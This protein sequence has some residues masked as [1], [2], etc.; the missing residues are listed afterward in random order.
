MALLLLLGL[1]LWRSAEDE[2]PASRTRP[3]PRG[4]KTSSRA[5]PQPVSGERA[6]DDSPRSMG[7]P[8][9]AGALVVEVLSKDAPL[10]GASVQLYARQPAE[11]LSFPAQWIGVDSGVTGADG[12]WTPPVAPGSYYVTVHAEGLAPGYVTVV[13][14]PGPARTRVRLNL[15]RAAELSGLILEKE[16]G[17]PI[18]NAEI[19]VTPPG[20]MSAPQ[21]RPDSPEDEGLL[22]TSNEAGEFMLSGL[23]PGTYRVEAQASGYARVEIPVFGIPQ[24]RLTLELSRSGQLEGTVVHADGAPAPGAEVSTTSSQYD[25]TVLTDGEGH[26][27]IDVPPGTYTVSSRQGEETGVLDAVAV[28]EGDRVRGLRVTLGAGARLSGTMLRKD[29]SPVIGAKVETWRRMAGSS[30]LAHRSRALAVTDEHG[31]FTL[32]PLAPGTHVPGVALPQRGRYR[33]PPVTLAAGEHASVVWTCEPRDDVTCQVPEATEGSAQPALAAIRG[34]VLHPLGI[35][36]GRIEVII[37]SGDRKEGWNYYSDFTGDRFDLRG[38]APGLKH[39]AVKAEDMAATVAVE[40][41][42]GELK[43]LE[44]TVTPGVTMKGRLIDEASRQPLENGWVH[45]PL[46]YMRNTMGRGGTGK[47]GRFSFAGVQPGEFLL[48]VTRGTQQGILRGAPS[49]THPVKVLPDQDNDVGD[50]IVPTP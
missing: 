10:P 38:L 31:A 2:V 5:R 1:G 18:E 11:L 25:A 20:V 9:H 43:E 22:A 37:P 50:I 14:P 46:I 12:R 29:G 8:S 23:A 35:P 16:T 6:L 26:F 13:Q 44:V 30:G 45:H 33:P 21:A 28:D 19:L 39:F 47:D 15:E 49:T 41:Q 7:A 42:P 17:K 40:L 36:V 48:K 27:A 32:G 34:R 24:S 4:P 3:G